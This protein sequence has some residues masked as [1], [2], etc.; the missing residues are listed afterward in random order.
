MEL[1][2][3]RMRLR[4]ILPVR[5][6]RKIR[7]KIIEHL[8]IIEQEDWIPDL[9]IVTIHLDHCFIYVIGLLDRSRCI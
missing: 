5:D 2:R 6:A 8:A 1:E 4:L 7:E 9:E 3:A